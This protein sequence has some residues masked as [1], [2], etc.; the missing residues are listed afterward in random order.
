MSLDWQ[1]VSREHPV[2]KLDDARGVLDSLAGMMMGYDQDV[3]ADGN[4]V[5]ARARLSVLY[6]P[7]ERR[8]TAVASDPF[9]G[10]VWW[11][12]RRPPELS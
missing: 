7:G 9:G 5:D 8:F 4:L 12:A 2:I 10:T 11:E 3:V 6:R 1:Q